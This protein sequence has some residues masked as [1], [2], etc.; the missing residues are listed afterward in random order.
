MTRHCILQIGT[1]KTG[2]T[3]LQSFLAQNRERL[4]ARGIQYPRFPGH[5]NH[6]ALVAYAMED[7]RRDPLRGA[8]GVHS[9][10]AVTGFRRRIEEQ[11]KAELSDPGS[12]IFCSEHCHSRLTSLTEVRRLRDLL[13]PHFDHIDISVYLR[14][15]DKV[16]TSLYSTRLKSG[17]TDLDV[18]PRTDADDPYF[19]Y[20][21]SLALWEEVFG[22][23]NVHVRLFD[24]SEFVNGDVIDDF[25]AAWDLGTPR[26]YLAVEKL[27]QSID[28]P[29]QDFLR[30]VNA[31]LEPLP[32]LP[33]EVVQGPL[34]DALARHFSGKGPL[35]ARSA[36]E[37]FYMK[38]RDLNEAVRWRY[39]PG[40]E[41]LFDE[42]FDAYPA[43]DDRV[44]FGA[45]EV[46]R[47]AARLHGVQTREIRRLE[48]EIQ[49]RDGHLA[50]ER[51]EQDVALGLFRR[52]AAHL[53]D[54]AEAAR[55]LAE[56]LHR[57]ERHREASE[58]ARRATTLRPGHHEY[59][60]FLGVTLQ[61]AGDLAGAQAA[62]ARAL[63]IDPDHAP[64]RQ[65]LAAIRARISETHPAS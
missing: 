41:T 55:T 18:L 62:Q 22:R 42:N 39:F 1:E 8:F 26:D 59:W 30:R 40:R 51:G 45:D 27:N 63:E 7:R 34:A 11:A 20:D 32:G 33:K 56:F 19:N 58:E 54:H 13:V 31:T 15:Q 5:S 65:T 10:A 49:I 3:T 23:R 9:D 43:S 53:P 4:Q 35:P 25:L 44:E 24:R 57:R 14:R 17:S 16:A 48:A 60:H 52:A 50:W 38:Y 37:A 12:T 61:A 21:R 29:A 47:I 36:A 46:A 64:T 2:T 28:A 6:T